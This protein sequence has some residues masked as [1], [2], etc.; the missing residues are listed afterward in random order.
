M[1]FVMREMKIKAVVRKHY[2]HFLFS[3]SFFFFFFFFFAIS[4]PLPRHLEVPRPGVELELQFLAYTTATAMPDP[5]H[6][7]DLHHS[8]WQG[9]ILNPLSKARYETRI[10]IDTTWVRNLPSHD[11]NSLR[12]SYIPYYLYFYILSFHTRIR[13]P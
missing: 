11:R 5:S 8:S 13:T 3:S 4:W 10:P 12:C 7:C 1:S 9:W 6:V 2:I